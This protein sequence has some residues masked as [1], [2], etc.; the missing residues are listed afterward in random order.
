MHPIDGRA[1]SRSAART[2]RAQGSAR[3]RELGKLPRTAPDRLILQ[4]GGHDMNRGCPSMTTGDRCVGHV[5]GTAGEKKPGSGLAA[6]VTSWA[7]G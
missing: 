7:G 2:E 5:G 3:H 1:V 6:T 4:L